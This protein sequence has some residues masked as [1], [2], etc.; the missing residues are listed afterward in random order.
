M[1]ISPNTPV[2]PKARAASQSLSPSDPP[3]GAQ[4]SVVADAAAEREAGR[5]VRVLL[6]D[7]QP[8]VRRGLAMR[9][10][11]EPDIEVSGEAADGT[12]ALDATAA[13]APDVV[14]MDVRMEGVDGIEATAALRLAYPEVAVVVLTLQDDAETR[15][16]AEAAGASGFVGKHEPEGLLVEEIMRSARP[17]GNGP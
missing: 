14:I 9:L 15:E 1:E 13:H 7:D 16:R 3:D 6:V 12:G 17:T 2:P 4:T 11:I 10:E 8:M 5:K